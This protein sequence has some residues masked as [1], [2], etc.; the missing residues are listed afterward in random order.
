M[1]EFWRRLI[2][3]GTQERLGKDMDSTWDIFS[4]KCRETC[5]FDA[6]QRICN[7]TLSPFLPKLKEDKKIGL[8]FGA[9]DS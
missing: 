5:S 3:M 4:T 6:V 7:Q 8:K 2:L 1:S 9:F